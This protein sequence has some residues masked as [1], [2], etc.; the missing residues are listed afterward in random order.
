MTATANPRTSTDTTTGVDVAAVAGVDGD[1]HAANGA[2]GPHRE[3]AD[4]EPGLVRDTTVDH[5]S[6]AGRGLSQRLVDRIVGSLT[7]ATEIG[8]AH[9]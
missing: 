1:V 4:S 3:R 8:R 6:P 7:Q 5:G 2:G 9:V